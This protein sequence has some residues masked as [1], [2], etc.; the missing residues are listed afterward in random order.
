MKAVARWPSVE[1]RRLTVSVLAPF[2]IVA[3]VVGLVMWGSADMREV[4]HG[5]LGHVRA[6]HDGDAYALVSRGLRA[7]VGEA[8]FSSY[9][10]RNIPHAR[11]SEGE[12]IN[13]FNGDFSDACVEVW[14]TRGG[15]IRE[16]VYVV[17]VKED[18]AWRVAAVTED[19]PDE[20]DDD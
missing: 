4:S 3:A 9:L 12:W 13:G 8:D 18:G 17:L 19:E 1:R 11:A 6:H 14:L 10:D 2:G 5:L 15:W 7:T 20:C 16:T